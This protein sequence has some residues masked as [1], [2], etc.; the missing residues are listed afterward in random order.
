MLRERLPNIVVS[1]LTFVRLRSINVY[2]S[3]SGLWPNFSYEF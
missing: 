2:S 3:I 1:R